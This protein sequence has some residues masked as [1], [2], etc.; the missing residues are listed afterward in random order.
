MKESSKSRLVARGGITVLLTVLFL[1]LVVIIPTVKLFLFS[2]C[3]VF[4][5]IMVIEHGKKAA[6][7]TYLAAAFLGLIILPNKLIMIPYVLY[8]GYYGIIKSLFEQRD[9]L[10][11]EWFLKLGSY[12]LAL[13]ICYRLFSGIFSLSLNSRLPLIVLF[14]IAEVYLF[15]Y[16]YCYSLAVSYYNS[17]FKNIL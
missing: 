7:I 5:A 15:I 11:Q 16:D 3:T 14:F 6:F 2:L 4:L 12:N 9:N 1:Y 13:L 10:I 17:F 8:F